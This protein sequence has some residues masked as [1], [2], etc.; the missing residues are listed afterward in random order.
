M[1]KIG[2]NQPCPCGSGKKYKR[3]CA[4]DAPNLRRIRINLP[5]PADRIHSALIDHEGKRTVFISNDIIS[6]TLHRDLPEIAAAFD[7]LCAAQI[8]ELDYAAAKVF[9]LSAEIYTRAPLASSDLF[10]TLWTLILNATNT[11]VAQLNLI[12]SGFRLQPGALA[13][14]VVEILCV[15]CHLSLH[16]EDLRRFQEGNL[17]STRTLAAA[18]KVL[19]P[20]GMFYGQLSER[21]VHIS[22]LHV[23]INPVQK[24]ES[25]DASLEINMSHVRT[26][27][28][29]ILVITELAFFPWLS[30]PRYWKSVGQGAYQYDPHPEEYAWMRKF[31]P[32][33]IDIA[34]PEIQ[35]TESGC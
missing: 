18:K 12:R 24:Y 19:P 21:F 5:F 1:R 6:N 33:S 16:P 10:R 29:L 20:I 13:R 30:A 9:S 3:C 7:E 23:G 31:L 25:D 15:V 22:D 34:E 4:N 32:G 2:R 27:V 17:P 8:E 14:Q 26:C 11:A 28:W 35:G